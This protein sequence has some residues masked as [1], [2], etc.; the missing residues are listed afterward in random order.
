MSGGV[1]RA[2]G[3][4]R[5][6]ACRRCGS[7]TVGACERARRAL[8]REPDPGERRPQVL[9]DVDG[10]RLERRDV[11]HAAPLGGGRRRLGREA[12]D[13][14]QERGEGLARAGGSEDQ[15]VVARARSPATPLLGGRGLGERGVEPGPDGGE[16]RSRLTG[17]PYPQSRTS[18]EPPLGCGRC[19]V[20]S[21]GTV[22]GSSS[23]R[24]RSSS[25][26]WSGPSRRS[27][28]RRPRHRPRSQP[29]VR[30]PGVRA[31]RWCWSVGSWF[32][33]GS[34]SAR[35]IVFSGRVLV[36]GIVEATSSSWTDPSRSRGR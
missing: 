20:P 17:K 12:V 6:P 15:R 7:P 10:E 31:T 22:H 25:S 9:L 5:S 23:P 36:E 4:A 32:R 30:R 11:E 2:S 19:S 29:P 26:R 28:P 33:K 21:E 34:P 35:S 18:G 13:R 14:P 16:K 24:S 1:R 8:G 27:P 3:G